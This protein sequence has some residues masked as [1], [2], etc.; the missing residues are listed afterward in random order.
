M[1]R[2]FKFFKNF[3]KK[4]RKWFHAILLFFANQFRRVKKI[5]K[6]YP[7]LSVLA[8]LLILLV[9]IIIGNNLRK[10]GKTEEVN[11]EET[12]NV[13][14]Y[15]IG[16]VPRITVNGKIEK[17]HVVTLVAQSAGIV[18]KIHIKAGQE[19]KKGTKIVSLSSN[20]NGAVMPSVQR[21]IAAT[22]YQFQKDNINL[23]KEIIQK[24][25]D[26]ANKSDENTDE[27][28]DIA[29]KSR[30]VTEEILS[31][32]RD[33]LQTIDGLIEFYEQMSTSTLTDAATDENVILGLNQ[34]KAGLLNGVAAAESSLRQLDYSGSDE[35]PPAELSNFAREVTQKQLDLQE[36]TLDLNLEIAALNLRVAQIAE[37]LMFPTAPYAG[38]I[39]RIFVRPGQSVQPG[40]PIA[41]LTGDSSTISVV[42]LVSKD[43]AQSISPVTESVITVGDLSFNLYPSHIATEPTD[44]RLFAIMYT[45]PQIGE[46]AK[47]II[48]KG[49]LVESTGSSKH[50]VDGQ[51][52]SISVPVGYADTPSS[53]PFIPID[54]VFQS[55]DKS[56]V[57]IE[58]NGLAVSREITLGIVYGRYVEVQS[59]LEKD[60]T[61]LLDRTLI[62]GDPV[63]VT[64]L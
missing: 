49:M 53:F 16:S 62:E 58:E 28:Q 63:Q 52:I 13:S 27:L 48:E 25:R 3:S 29:E 54:S 14:G 26:I 24:N 39:E 9:L 56:L 2:I 36:K 4:L 6:H 10:P 12:K 50:S 40:T 17:S 64:N 41:V 1:R 44:G 45:L 23:Q 42:A 59:G 34:Q 57:F 30:S 43:I 20:Y 38:K 22:G 32:S 61:I 21:Q 37:S 15:Q 18:Q 8:V 7:F 35:N 5:I 33:S 55:Q 51:F 47:S 11:R 46:G 19:V 60:D 31:V